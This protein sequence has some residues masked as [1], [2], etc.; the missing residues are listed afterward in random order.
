MFFY[1]D[2]NPLDTKKRSMFKAVTWRV[3]GSLDTILLAYIFTGD[4][5][6]AASIG[7]AEVFT[8]MI[9]YYFHERAWNRVLFGKQ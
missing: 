7:V 2:E 6:V 8:K 9:L 1:T 3:T 5:T 4:L